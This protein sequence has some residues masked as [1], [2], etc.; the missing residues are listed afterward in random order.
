MMEGSGTLEEQLAAI[1]IKVPLPLVY[2]SILSS[3][4]ALYSTLS[5]DFAV[6]KEK[7]LPDIGYR[8]N[9]IK[10]SRYRINN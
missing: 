10:G 6:P 5:I 7:D 2:L 9:L 3:I 4:A 8:I 1:G